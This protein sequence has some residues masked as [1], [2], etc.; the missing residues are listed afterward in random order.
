M[1]WYND[2]TAI[3]SEKM[4]DAAAGMND[5]KITFTTVARGE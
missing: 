1:I 3:N 4:Y 5:I 2:I